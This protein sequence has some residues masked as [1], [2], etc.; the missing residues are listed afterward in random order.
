MFV[1]PV[2]KDAAT[3]DFFKFAEEPTRP[4]DISAQEIGEKRESWIQAWTEVVLR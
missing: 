2:N 1:Y 4:A 3:P